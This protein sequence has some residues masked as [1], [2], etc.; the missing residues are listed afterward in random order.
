MNLKRINQVY[1]KLSYLNSEDL[2]KALEELPDPNEKRVL[3]SI[4]S[5]YIFKQRPSYGEGRLAEDLEL[6]D[7]ESNK[8]FI[9]RGSSFLVEAY[10]SPAYQ[11]RIKHLLFQVIGHK[12]EP[13]VWSE[14]LRDSLTGEII[15]SGSTVNS[16]VSSLGE[17]LFFSSKSIGLLHRADQVLRSWRTD[18]PYIA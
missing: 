5:S 16:I 3:G 2:K 15:P 11:G 10:F 4:V 18:Y 6:R 12:P 8:D 13:K 7:G 9:E 1:S 17:N 14:D